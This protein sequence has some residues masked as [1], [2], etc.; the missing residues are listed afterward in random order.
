MT[1]VLNASP[2]TNILSALTPFLFRETTSDV[3]ILVEFFRITGTSYLQTV[4]QDMIVHVETHAKATQLMEG[5]NAGSSAHANEK[6]ERL[7]ALATQLVSSILKTPANKLPATLRYVCKQ[8]HS[9]L[10]QCLYEAGFSVNTEE[11]QAL[12]HLVA[13]QLLVVRFFS[14]GLTCPALYLLPDPRSEFSQDSCIT[15]SNILIGLLGLGE[16]SSLDK[17]GS[18]KGSESLSFLGAA[19]PLHHHMP[20]LSP[21][22]EAF[23]IAVH[24]SKTMQATFE[25]HRAHMLHWLAQA[26]DFNELENRPTGPL[27][28]F[29]LETYGSVLA[30]WICENALEFLNATAGD[31]PLMH[32]DLFSFMAAN[33]HIIMQMDADRKMFKP[34]PVLGPGIWNPVQYARAWKLEVKLPSFRTQDMFA[35]I[36]TGTALA[37]PLADRSIIDWMIRSTGGNDFLIAIICQTS[38]STKLAASVVRITAKRDYH[39]DQVV[40]RARNCIFFVFPSLPPLLRLTSLFLVFAAKIHPSLEKDLSRGF[41][42]SR[43]TRSRRTGASFCIAS[44]QQKTR[45]KLPNHL[46]S[47][48][49]HSLLLRGIKTHCGSTYWRRGHCRIG[50]WRWKVG[51]LLGK[52]SCA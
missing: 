25:A 12:L 26:G 34:Q 7:M 22:C 35:W 37:T 19:S 49:T 3:A 36:P 48:R 20:E 43:S 5:M 10:V 28:F 29:V 31:P 50:G 21:D 46:R 2:R 1:A 6:A 8:T 41:G 15:L 32:I 39:L 47:L 52:F 40:K 16:R 44:H 51:S 45:P 18:G 11:S 23:F 30:R 42:S 14:L 33:K 4:L 38:P 17:P 27:A 9:T 24:K 13:S